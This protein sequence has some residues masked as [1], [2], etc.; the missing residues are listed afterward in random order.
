LGVLV[1]WYHQLGKDKFMNPYESLKDSEK[2][3]NAIKT[4]LA[5]GLG[6]EGLF[7]IHKFFDSNNFPFELF[8]SVDNQKFAENCYE[9][10][11]RRTPGD[12]EIQSQTAQLEGLEISRVDFLINILLSEE[13]RTK[14]PSDYRR[15]R[16]LI[17]R[18][19]SEASQPSNADTLSRIPKNLFLGVDDRVFI[20]NAY[21]TFSGR[22]PEI[23]AL[24]TH[25]R[26]LENSS[27]NRRRLLEALAKEK[28]YGSR[29]EYDRAALKL[30][31]SWQPATPQ[32]RSFASFIRDKLDSM[33]FKQ[34]GYN[35]AKGIFGAIEVEGKANLDA[36]MNE[37]LVQIDARHRGPEDVVRNQLNFYLD[38][39][40]NGPI[41]DV[42]CGRGVFLDLLR[43][44]GLNAL[45]LDLNEAQ[46]RECMERGHA[47]KCE[48]VMEHMSQIPD[49]HYGAISLFHVIEHLEFPALVAL[50]K[51]AYR[52]LKPGG[53]VLIETP[54]PENIF[55]STHFFF[56]D[57]THKK[58]ITEQF[59]TTV[60]DVVGFDY[61]R[62]PVSGYLHRDLGN[63]TGNIH[64]DSRLNA[65]G[66][67]GFLAVKGIYQ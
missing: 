59:I 16:D 18:L 46:V 7:P 60:L 9:V 49:N 62:L 6:E 10:F 19:L 51:E 47:A 38:Y 36:L 1:D 2:I 48:D 17:S 56:V 23:D 45:G 40:E 41:L 4:F 64:L 33:Q 5:R 57:P 67:F 44:Q 20:V 63:P 34:K 24:E 8:L 43:D 66:N 22:L 12:Q 35:D 28:H 21:I 50:F 65:S 39:I 54:N 30:V 53:R 3:T 32:K 52:V 37:I 25:L 14:A 42:G 26:N 58:P 61:L 27:G 55:V 13:F 29:F 11:L 15:I 31:H